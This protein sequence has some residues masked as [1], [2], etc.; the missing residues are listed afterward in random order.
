MI[1][2]SFFKLGNCIAKLLKPPKLSGTLV[3]L[4]AHIE[5]Y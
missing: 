4:T 1:S 3:R 5:Y 2:T